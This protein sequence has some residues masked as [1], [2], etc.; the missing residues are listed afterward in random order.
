MLLYIS[1]YFLIGIVLNILIDLI[2]DVVERRGFEEGGRF[3]N[4]TKLITLI[5]WPL[6]LIVTIIIIIKNLRNG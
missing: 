2:F 5:L 3:D 6:M 4:F 1:T